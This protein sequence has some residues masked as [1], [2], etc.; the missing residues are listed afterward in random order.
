MLSLASLIR[1]FHYCN[2][3]RPYFTIHDSDFKELTAPFSNHGSDRDSDQNR[4]KQRRTGLMLG[5]TN[6][7]FCK[8]LNKVHL[9]LSKNESKSMSLLSGRTFCDLGQPRTNH[10]KRSKVL[11]RSKRSIP[12]L[13]S[14][15]LTKGISTRT[16]PTSIKSSKTSKQTPDDRRKWDLR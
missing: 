6:P 3:L 16:V 5:V 8:T 10:P 7:F 9:N 2:E 13:A 1:P 4:E 15:P 11:K 12:L 14:S